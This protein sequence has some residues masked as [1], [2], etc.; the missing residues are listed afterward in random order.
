M[1]RVGQLYQHGRRFPN[2]LPSALIWFRRAADAGSPLGAGHAAA[3]LAA[4]QGDAVD[5]P[6]A[7]TLARQA[8]AGGHPEFLTDI[9][10]LLCQ[11]AAGV[12]RDVPHGAACLYEAAR[13]GDPRAAAAFSALNPKD[14]LPPPPP[15]ASRPA[16]ATTR[17][18]AA[19]AV[20]IGDRNRP[21]P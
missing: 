17:P 4:G 8:A 3:M 11:G 10:T 15:P 9:G 13:Y 16:A 14:L 5:L 1:D 19:A 20:A 2:H 6:K 18:A 21:P 7:I 12:A